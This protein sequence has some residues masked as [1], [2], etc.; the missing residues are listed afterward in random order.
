MPPILLLHSFRHLGLMF[1]T[2][3][4]TYPGMPAQFAYPAA[5]GDLRCA[6]F[7]LARGCRSKSQGGT[8]SGLGVQCGGDAGSDDGDRTGNR[9]WCARVHGA[10][11][12]DTRVL[13]AGA[14]GDT[15]HH[16]L[17]S[18]RRSNEHGLTSGWLA[19]RS[20]AWHGNEEFPCV[21][22]SR[23]CITSNR[24]PPTKRSARPRSNSSESSA[25]LQSP[26]KRTNS[27]SLARS[28]RWRERLMNSS[29]LSLRTPRP[30][31]VKSKFP[32]P[33]PGRRI[34]FALPMRDTV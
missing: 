9:V 19:A 21:E 29:I 24:P 17:G 8:N 12:L 5:L 22:T 25:A 6:G 20:T 1:L 14:A 30:A 11:V 27:P 3:G 23:L 18:S 31:I 33:A 13:G 4:A 34:V 15:L 32:R 26:P 10:G 28:T 2:R 7:R 16:V